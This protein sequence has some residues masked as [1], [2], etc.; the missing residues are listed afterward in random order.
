MKRVLDTELLI[1]A[2]DN[3]LEGYMQNKKIVGRHADEVIVGGDM[4]KESKRPFRRS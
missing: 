2:A 4:E 3:K 1:R